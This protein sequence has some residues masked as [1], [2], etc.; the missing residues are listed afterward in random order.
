MNAITLTAFYLI[1]VLAPFA[2]SWMQVRAPRPF[3]DELATGTGM[4]AFAIILVEFALSGRF[5]S[6]SRKIGMD[7]TMRYHQLIARSALVLAIV[8][9]FLYRAPFKQPLPWNDG[10]TLNLDAT[11]L[12][13]GTLA[14]VL[15][16]SLVLLSIARNQLPYTYE[17]WRWMHGLGALLIAGLVLHHAVGM[18][19]YSQD[20]ALWIFWM[21]LFVV[22]S[23]SLAVV[24]LIKPVLQLSRPWS[25][26]R[27]RPLAAKTWEITL[28]P[29][30]HN[31]L[32]YEAGQFAWV[33]IGNSPFSLCEHPFSISSAP[34]S[35][36]ELQFIIKE[37][38]DFTNTIGQVKTGTRAYVDGPHGNLVLSKRHGKGIA[39][40]AGGVGIAPLLGI[41]RELHLQSDKRPK[42]LVYGNR[43]EEQIAARGELDELSKQH[44]TNVVHVLSEPN[45]SWNGRTGLIDAKLI[46]SLW[47]DE[48]MR[49]WVFILCGPAPMMTGVE[50]TLIE[51]GVPSNQI[52]AERFDYD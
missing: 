27:V 26:E 20:P 22:A 31:G 35:G 5:R 52:L 11:S 36:P 24:Y 4:L 28:A 2:L 38:G 48:N 39:L 46:Q 15:L 23:A 6:I 21:T 10:A 25:V 9:P 14:W 41:L 13:T 7:T 37:L 32:D 34:K 30:G 1:V 16:P 3:W 43:T 33:N 12:A 40:I 47:S 17:T 49:D 45:E 42:L 8:H 19:R 51:L 29:D 18:G 50:A 44:G